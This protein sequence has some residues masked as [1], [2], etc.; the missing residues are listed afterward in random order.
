M[1]R[2]EVEERLI[3]NA[4]AIIFFCRTC[5][6]DDFTYHLSKQI[7]RSSSSAALNYGE[8]QSAESR[9]D[10]VH[11]LGLVL[12][13]LRETGINLKILRNSGICPNDVLVQKIIDETESLIRIFQ[14]SVQTAKKNLS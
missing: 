1:D 12:K 13:E 14:K 10:F 4:N 3:S 8:A 2:K 6:F 11:K 7:V 5:R 9:K